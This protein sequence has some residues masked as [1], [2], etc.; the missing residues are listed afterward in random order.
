[1][2]YVAMEKELILKEYSKIN[3]TGVTVVSESVNGDGVTT[4][5]DSSE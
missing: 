3:G 5:V 1:M 4:S 2:Y